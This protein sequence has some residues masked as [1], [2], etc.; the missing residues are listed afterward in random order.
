MLF[1]ERRR[2]NR[3]KQ[4]VPELAALCVERGKPIELPLHDACVG[5]EKHSILDLPNSFADLWAML[6]VLPLNQSQHSR[7][8]STYWSRS[9]FSSFALSRHRVNE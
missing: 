6:T 4:K 9:S 1:G 2:E 8:F 7:C 5:L 3:K